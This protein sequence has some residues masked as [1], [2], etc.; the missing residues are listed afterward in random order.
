M[1][2]EKSDAWSIFIE[3]FKINCLVFWKVFEG[4]EESNAFRDRLI[5]V[6]KN[7]KSIKEQIQAFERPHKVHELKDKIPRSDN[8]VCHFL[9]VFYTYITEPNI[10]KNYDASMV[11]NSQVE[12]LM[13]RAWMSDWPTADS[14]TKSSA[15]GLIKKH[16]SENK[17]ALL[18]LKEFINYLE[19]DDADF[20]PKKYT[21]APFRNTKTI[22]E[23]I[24]NRWVLEQLKNK[25]ISNKSFEVKKKTFEE[26][27]DLKYP[28]WNSDLG[29]N[30][31]DEW[32]A[33]EILLRSFSILNKLYSSLSGN[34]QWDTIDD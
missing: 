26:H 4:Q 7:K 28:S 22:V 23:Y 11:N 9:L 1:H 15:I 21:S 18:D 3:M 27:A 30:K 10:L 34:I 20:E 33:E 17:F 29:L 32:G 6:C 16:I 5:D 19:R 13:P 31:Y 2:N 12:H 8:S 14:F 24:G 25:S